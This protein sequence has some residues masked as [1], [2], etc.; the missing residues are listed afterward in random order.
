MATKKPLVITNGQI[1]QLQTGDNLASNDLFERLNDSGVALP[2]GTPVYVPAT[3]EV[4]KAQANAAGTM[5]VFGLVADTSIADATSGSIQTDGVLTATTGQWDTITGG[6]GGLTPNSVYFL[7]AVTAGMLT[8]TAPVADG[9]FVARVGL[10]LSET[11]LEIT[12]HAPIK[13]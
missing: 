2:K 12:F 3:G 10:A 4:A 9:Q 5:K 8:A 1:E 11:E 7:D 6:S 13:L